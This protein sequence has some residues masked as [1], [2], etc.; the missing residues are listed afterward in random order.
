MY[1]FV[2]RDFE[3]FNARL[4]QDR[5]IKIVS[6]EEYDD[7]DRVAYYERCNSHSSDI[8]AWRDAEFGPGA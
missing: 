2:F 8:D 1:S 5:N 7:G 3:T 6:I 4:K